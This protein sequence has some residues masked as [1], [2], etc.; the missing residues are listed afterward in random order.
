MKN[1]IVLLLISLLFSC[2]AKKSIVQSHE[3]LASIQKNAISNLI[4]DQTKVSTVM[5]AQSLDNTKK[6][7]TKIKYDTSKPVSQSTG[8]P[9]VESEVI[10]VVEKNGSTTTKETHQV[11]NNV[12]K[13]EIDNSKIELKSIT[14]KKE[15]IKTEAPAVKYYFYIFLLGIAIVA[16]LIIYKNLEKIKAFFSFLKS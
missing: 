1:L 8:K 7:T 5:D 16:V 4:D 2:A 11:Q 15:L 6:T 14:D 13:I 10:T 3:D 9:P 12:K